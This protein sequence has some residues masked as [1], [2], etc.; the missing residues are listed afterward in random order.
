VKSTPIELAAMDADE[1]DEVHEIER[2]SQPSPWPRSVFA[3]ELAREWAR[4]LAREW[5]RVVVVREREVGDPRV[6]AFANY[7]LVRDEVHLLNLAVHPARRRRGHARR[8]MDHLL[9]FARAHRCHYLTLEVRRSNTAAIG[10]YEAYGFRSV[11][12]RP[13]YYQD[14]REDAIV[15]ALELAD[16]PV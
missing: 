9:E 13:R 5:A 7:W 4:V 15:M 10:L 16:D 3:E 12:V 11:G 1:V 14:S 8:L 6:V 2:L